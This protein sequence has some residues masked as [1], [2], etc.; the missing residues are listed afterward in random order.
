MITNGKDVL[1]DVPLEPDPF[2]TEELGPTDIQAIAD[3]DL[4]GSRLLL[5][6]RA[7]ETVEIDGYPGGAVELSCTFQ[8]AENCRFASAR[9]VLK[10]TTPAGVRF[11]DIQP[12]EVRETE[13]VKFI[14]ESKGKLGL[15][16][17]NIEGGQEAGAKA[18]YT[19]YHCAVTGA[20]QGTHIASWI[21]KENPHRLDGLGT[22]LALAFTILSVGSVAGEV[23][24]TARLV[25]TGLPGV[26][27]AIR[28]LILGP[29]K[30]RHFPVHF[31]IPAAQPAS[32]SSRFL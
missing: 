31:D 22:S 20:G 9:L 16:Y 12:A 4:K 25:R 6:H 3:E 10:L 15:K 29:R 30:G 23:I 26:A 28:D 11:V 1:I 8:P 21:F 19:T 27:D 7:I 32:V 5:V 17:L 24:A 13:P 18:E 14:L 2:A